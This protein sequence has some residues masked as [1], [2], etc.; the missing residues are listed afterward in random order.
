[1]KMRMIAG[2]LIVFI[3]KPRPG[4]S[5]EQRSVEALFV[6]EPDAVPLYVHP[7]AHRDREPI[8]FATITYNSP[9]QS[10]EHQGS[11]CQAAANTAQLPGLG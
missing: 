8:E 10:G 3:E 9:L 6:G 7:C 2:Q 1:M 5:T 4:A 11:C